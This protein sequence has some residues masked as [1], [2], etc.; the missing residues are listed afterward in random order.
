MKKHPSLLTEEGITTLTIQS[1]PVST[2]EA[3]LTWLSYSPEKKKEFSGLSEKEI[4]IQIYATE[5]EYGIK[6]IK[7]KNPMAKNQPLPCGCCDPYDLFRNLPYK[8]SRCKKDFCRDPKSDAVRFSQR[9]EICCSQCIKDFQKKGVNILSDK[10]GSPMKK[11][12]PEPVAQVMVP[13]HIARRALLL[14]QEHCDQKEIPKDSPKGKAAIAKYEHEFCMQWLESQSPDI[15]EDLKQ[16]AKSN[17]HTPQTALS[18]RNHFPVLYGS[19]GLVDKMSAGDAT[20]KKEV[21]RR[22]SGAT[23]VIANLYLEKLAGR[24]RKAKAYPVGANE[25]LRRKADIERYASLTITTV[26]TEAVSEAMAH[27][28]DQLMKFVERE[29]EGKSASELNSK[30]F[31]DRF[32]TK[33]TNGIR[34]KA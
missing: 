12:N 26:L 11:S 30:E 17:P 22:L 1:Y 13:P 16:M 23:Q 31:R 14:A 28:S 4:I 25:E 6:P 27:P 2:E 33:L 15:E 24:K 21:E 19:G 9:G 8:C 10:K 5:F 32:L 34:Q 29:T 18:I 3:V 7:K 20:A